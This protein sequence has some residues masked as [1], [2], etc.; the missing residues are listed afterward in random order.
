MEKDIKFYFFESFKIINSNRLL[1][2]VH[3]I[4]ITN[5]ATKNSVLPQVFLLLLS[6]LSFLIMPVIY[7][8]FTEIIKEEKPETLFKVFKK[9]LSN[10]FIYL[11]CLMA[12]T[13]LF[14]F[15]FLRIVPEELVPATFS[16]IRSI[17]T[18]LL[19]YVF[20]LVFLQ[21][22][23][24][25]KFTTVV[26]GVKCLFAHFRYSLPLILLNIGSYFIYQIVYKIFESALLVE[27]ANI[28]M[29]LFSRFLPSLLGAFISITLFIAA[30]MILIKEPLYKNYI[31]SQST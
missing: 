9:H 5:L 6:I 29:L 23:Q 20:P 2:F 30:G 22:K 8:R 11:F 17:T 14:L 1:L 15:I 31:N 21:G 13:F 3:G 10:Y 24:L 18:S 4:A 19:L 26:S 27:N 12:P 7:G 25:I 28:L 16:V